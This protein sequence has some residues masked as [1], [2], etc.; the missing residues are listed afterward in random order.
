MTV[1]NGDDEGMGIRKC[2]TGFATEIVLTYVTKV[3]GRSK[4]G[5]AIGITRGWYW[6]RGFN[7]KFMG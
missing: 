2:K 7:Q 1:T 4:A 6:I 3:D 5:I